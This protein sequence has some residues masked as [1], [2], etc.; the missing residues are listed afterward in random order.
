MA[1]SIF[2]T[3]SPRAPPGGRLNETVTEGNWPEWL[4][5][6]GPVLV[7]ELGEG[8]EGHADAVGAVNVDVVKAP[9]PSQ[10]F[11]GTVITMWY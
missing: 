6:K 5:A 4:T 7:H 8:A 11:S 1:S 9:G 3:A 2:S 10:N